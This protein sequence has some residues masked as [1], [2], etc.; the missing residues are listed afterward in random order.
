VTAGPSLSSALQRD[1]AAAASICDRQLAD[2]DTTP[3]SVSRLVDQKVEA[4]GDFCRRHVPF[5][6]DAG[7]PSRAALDDFPIVDKGTLMLGLPRTVAEPGLSLEEL[8]RWVP[9][10]ERDGQ[11]RLF[12]DRYYVRR[13][14]GTT[15]VVGYFLWDHRQATAARNAQARFVPPLEQLPR[16]LVAVSPVVALPR[17]SGILQ[18]MHAIPLS[19]GLDGA[20]EQLNQLHP[21][22]VVGSPAFTAS[23]AMQQLAGR[24]R[25]NPT[26][27]AVWTERCLPHQRRAIEQAWGVEVIEPYG[28]SETSG[29]AVRCP[30]GNFHVLADHVHLELLD[31]EGRPVPVGGVAERVLVTRMCGPMQPIVRYEL[32]DVLV[33][34]PDQC[35]CGRAFPTLAEVR[36]RTRARLWLVGHDGRPV[37]L[38]AFVLIPVLED[39]PGLVRYQLRYDEPGS[40]EVA[41]VAR[42]GLDADR[43]R[44]RLTDA[45][46]D[47]HAVP[48]AITIVDGMLPDVWAAPPGS[49]DHHVRIAVEER[50]VLAWLQSGAHLPD[51]T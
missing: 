49:K 8:R 11:F 47:A 41:V 42:S 30:E 37:H 38:S 50:D 39:T 10:D 6:A 48:P 22:S 1:L 45:L 36:G 43:L 21:A 16:P 25:I 33:R 17:Y 23:L 2:T 9:T 12:R 5:Y 7:L 34:G 24:L 13:T 29:I 19:A 4:L 15:G 40:L 18:D 44:A 14:S 35:P 32:G 51:P 20:I 26:V 3:A 28:T 27:V 31:D 46:N